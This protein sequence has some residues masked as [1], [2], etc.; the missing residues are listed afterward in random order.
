MPEYAYRFR[1]PET[2]RMNKGKIA[3]FDEA[4]ARASLASDGVV[5]V[6]ELQR[7]P[8][9]PATER[10]LEYLRDLNV[11][12]MAGT[13]KWEASDLIDN[14]ERRR[15]PAGPRE[16]QLAARF[17]VF[18]TRFSSKDSIYRGIA[19]VCAARKDGRELA[20]WFVFRVYRDR[21]DR[22]SDAVIDDPF[23]SRLV[24]VAARIAADARL[25]AALRRGVREGKNW[26]WFGKFEAPDGALYQGESRETTVYRAARAELERTGLVS[27]KRQVVGHV[28]RQQQGSREYD[29][30][31]ESDFTRQRRIGCSLF[32]VVVLGGLLAF[33]MAAFHWLIA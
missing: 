22:V 4:D 6:Q 24:A 23:D 29:S 15:V 2:G 32:G 1:N 16:R 30:S 26:R 17:K 11:Q 27:E 20:I 28:A 13:T 14:A 7:L 8:D 25:M 18:V 33:S 9:P 19:Q 12:V 21:C 5:D 31:H 3:A 10:Q